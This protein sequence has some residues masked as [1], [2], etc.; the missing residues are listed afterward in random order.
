MSRRPRRTH[1]AAFK[2]KVALEDQLLDRSE[3]V[4]RITAMTRKGG[5][6]QGPRPPIFRTSPTAPVHPRAFSRHLADSNL[7]HGAP[8]LLTQLALRPLAANNAM[9]CMQYVTA[10]ASA[11]SAAAAQS[12][13]VL[14][15]LL[16]NLV[17]LP[18][19]AGLTA[20]GFAEQH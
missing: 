9:A 7:D 11:K 20:L 1:S 4:E 13:R 10:S 3:S 5:Q 15:G 12:M 17:F 14:A 2:A 6:A 19:F 8:D 18:T 16:D